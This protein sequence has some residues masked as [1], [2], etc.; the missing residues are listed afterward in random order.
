MLIAACANVDTRLCAIQAHVKVSE[1]LENLSKCVAEESV[2]DVCMISSKIKLSQSPE[3]YILISHMFENLSK[4]MM[5]M[6]GVMH[7]GLRCVPSLQA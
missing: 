2:R 5:S 7:M 6:C 3:S 4:S 1:H